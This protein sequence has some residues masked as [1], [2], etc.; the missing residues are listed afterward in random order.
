MMNASFEKVILNNMNF[1]DTETVRRYSIYLTEVE[2]NKN[3]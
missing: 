2:L 3:I 1:K